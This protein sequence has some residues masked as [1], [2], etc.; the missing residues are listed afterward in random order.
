MYADIMKDVAAG[1]F[2]RTFDSMEQ[3]LFTII[4]GGQ[5]VGKNTFIEKVFGQPFSYYSAEVNVGIDMAKNYDAVE[6]K[7]VCI[8]GEFD[9]TQK[10]QISFLKELITNASF[11][12]RRAYERASDRYELKQTFF[13]GSNFDEVLK[14]PSGARRFLIL[15]MPFINYEYTEHCDNEQ[16]VAQ[17]FHLYKSGHRM[18][19]ESKAWIMNF[20]RGETPENPI[21]LALESYVDR[22]RKK[23]HMSAQD[24]LSNTEVEE[25]IHDA[26]K[27]HNV[28]PIRFRQM[29]NRRKLS[30]R[31]NG[32]WYCNV[33]RKEFG[34]HIPVPNGRVKDEQ[35]SF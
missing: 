35:T 16:L 27:L 23:F 17:F 32:I 9:Q 24:W 19:E 18:K 4:R 34:R 29:L 25:I 33:A 12:A 26:C 22:I 10:V 13:S 20:N 21:E 3:N 5:G 1:I 31:S 15:D 11:T 8:I 28:P 7:L 6:G 30:K 2:R 14:D